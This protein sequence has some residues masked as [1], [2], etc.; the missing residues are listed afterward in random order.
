MI[1]VAEALTR[2]TAAFEPVPGET[3]AL[4]EGL[5]RVLAADV[6]ARLTQPPAAVSAMDGYAV[7]AADVADP[8]VRLRVVGHVPA[9]GVYEGTIGPGQAARIF[10]GAPVPAGAD[11][12]VIQEDTEADGDHVLI[13]AAAAQGRYIRPAGLDFRAGEV[14]LRAGQ[15]LGPRDI[16]LAAAMNWPWLRVR[17]RPRVAI[18]S[19]GDEIVLPGEPLGRSQIV[20]SNGP[21]LAAFVTACGAQP[22]HLGIATD[23]R[24]ALAALVAEAEGAD[25]LVTTGG[26][27]VGEHD[28]VREVLGTRGFDLDFW[29]IAMRPGK[30]LMFGRIGTTPILGLPGNPVSALVCAI[31][32]LGPAIDALLGVP[33]TSGPGERAYLGRDLPANDHRQE[34]L[35]A[36]LD[37]DSAGRRIAMPFER[38]DSSML[39]T[40]ARADCLVVRPPHA[41][42]AK[43]GE[44][45]EI[46]PLSI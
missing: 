17:R 15:R 33:A 18:L 41:A 45:I 36:R 31:L 2:I 6:T 39:A 16:G 38:Q 43:A 30:P 22:Q 46:I 14:G 34:Y 35:R 23:D 3:V 7:R 29:K 40:L 37:I 5:G 44:A 26:V 8:P 27:S 28:L 11:A 42:P 20:S 24:A 12:I 13:K 1:S 32:F 10:T 25:L 4:S 19:T 21:A 9:G